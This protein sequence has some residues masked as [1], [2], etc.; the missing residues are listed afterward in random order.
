VKRYHYILSLFLIFISAAFLSAVL[1]PSG[2]NQNFD[3]RYISGAV[4]T[5]LSPQ[6]QYAQLVSLA[7]ESCRFVEFLDRTDE[8]GEDILCWYKSEGVPD[9]PLNVAPPIQQGG[10]P[11]QGVC[12]CPKGYVTKLPD[13]G[14]VLAALAGVKCV[15]KVDIRVPMY[16]MGAC[17]AC[18]LNNDDF[19]KELQNNPNK[20]LKIVKKPVPTCG[21]ICGPVECGKTVTVNGHKGRIIDESKNMITVDVDGKI[22]KWIKNATVFN[23]PE[24]SVEG[25]KLVGKPE[26]RIKKNTK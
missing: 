4:V 17:P 6:M 26:E 19:K 22:K 2:H 1:S 25:K 14:P 12:K 16:G 21:T 18:Y 13:P 20:V 7:E 15:A 8:H 5:E 11:R 9:F 23:F 24:G 3:I 10:P